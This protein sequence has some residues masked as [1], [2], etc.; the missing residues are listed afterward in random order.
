MLILNTGPGCSDEFKSFCKMNMEQGSKYKFGITARVNELEDYLEN[1]QRTNKIYE[2]EFKGV[3]ASEDI[4]KFKLF[5]TYL[6]KEYVRRASSTIIK[7]MHKRGSKEKLALKMKTLSM[8]KYVLDLDEPIEY[9]ELLGSVMSGNE[10]GSAANYGYYEIAKYLLKLP[11]Q[12]KLLNIFNLY[13]IRDSSENYFAEFK[14]M[15]EQG[16]GYEKSMIGE[17]LCQDNLPIYKRGIFTFLNDKEKVLEATEF[18]KSI[19]LVNKEKVA[20]ILSKCEMIGNAFDPLG[21]IEY[22]KKIIVEEPVEDVELLL[23][24][25]N[26]GDNIRE[27][28]T[29]FN[30]IYYIKEIEKAALLMDFLIKTSRNLSGEIVG[31]KLVNHSDASIVKS[32]INKMKEA[33]IPQRWMDV[34]DEPYCKY[35]IHKMEQ[36]ME[37]C[38]SNKIIAE[39]M[40]IEDQ[41]NWDM[42]TNTHDEL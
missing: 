29:I 17:I 36:K 6:P 20:H 24:H 15:I 37:S 30:A 11:I 19:G 14:W 41:V 18:L 9:P 40:G 25:L 38:E 7:I 42:C 34:G 27:R 5:T 21:K 33:N 28:H 12:R 2:Y 39:Y 10:T 22:Y 26:L 35:T 32:V 1:D 23:D 31:Y 13:D 8:K 4:E 16:V 3:V